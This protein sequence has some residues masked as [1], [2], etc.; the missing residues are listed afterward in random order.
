[1]SKH[2]LAT[3]LGYTIFIVLP[4]FY[5]IMTIY[6]LMYTEGAFSFSKEYEHFESVVMQSSQ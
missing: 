6:N 3:I 1:M 2:S 5:M 4:F